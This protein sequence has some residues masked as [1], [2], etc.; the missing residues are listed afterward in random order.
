MHHR[1]LT[2]SRDP[3]HQ[4]PQIVTTK[5][6][7]RKDQICC[8][9]LDQGDFCPTG[10]NLEGKKH[11]ERCEDENGRKECEKSNVGER[12]GLGLR[13]RSPLLLIQSP[14]PPISQMCDLGPT[15]SLV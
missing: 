1:T 12:K 2:A 8:G 4:M 9:S 13:V 11:E 7:S 6:V 14:D 3:A 15:P 5:D 10:S